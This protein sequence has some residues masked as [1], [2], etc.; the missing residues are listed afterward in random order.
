[1][2]GICQ[3]SDN[4]FQGQLPELQP[5]VLASTSSPTAMSRLLPLFG[6][7]LFSFIGLSLAQQE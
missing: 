7:A 3:T 5:F 1:V 4:N 6:F 2:F